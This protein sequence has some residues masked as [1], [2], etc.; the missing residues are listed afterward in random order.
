VLV[1]KVPSSAH[2]VLLCVRV[3]QLDDSVIALL[4]DAPSIPVLSLTPLMPFDLDRLQ[5]AL[6]KRLVVGMPGV[7][8][9]WKSPDTIRYWLSRTTPTLIDQ[10]AASDP[11]IHAL[12]RA[13][14]RAGFR[15]HFRPQLSRL[16]P[17]TTIILF[18]LTLLLDLFDGNV[19][20]ALRDTEKLQLA[21]DAVRE[22]STIASRIG[23]AAPF[24]PIL[25]RLIGARR[26]RLSMALVRMSHPESIEFVERHFGSKTHLQ[27]IQIA[28][29]IVEIARSQGLPIPAFSKLFALACGAD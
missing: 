22:C 2:V 24:V 7:A 25:A 1:Q 3:E 20:L 18:P 19:E 10:I 11:A 4:N 14:Q 5:A 6:G 16:N 28:S 23:P 17:A 15:A 29:Q 27:S 26:L 9:Y 13:L 12:C 21:I 8:A